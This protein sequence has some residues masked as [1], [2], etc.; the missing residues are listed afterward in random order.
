L[1]QP[2]QRVPFNTCEDGSQ[3]FRNDYAAGWSRATTGGT[4]A[5]T[6]DNRGRPEVLFVNKEL[7]ISRRKTLLSGSNEN[8]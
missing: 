1:F 8:S 2:D 7:G 5:A 4:G 3:L 6:S